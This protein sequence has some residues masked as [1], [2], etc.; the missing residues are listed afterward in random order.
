MGQK[1]IAGEGPLGLTRRVCDAHIS[2]EFITPSNK[3]RYFLI[4]L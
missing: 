4:N 2:N 3:K 1:A